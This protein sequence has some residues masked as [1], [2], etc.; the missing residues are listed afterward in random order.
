M[1]VGYADRCNNS[2]KDEFGQVSWKGKGELIYSFI[3]SILTGA[4]PAVSADEVFEA[5]S[6]CLAIEK[7]SRQE[8]NLLSLN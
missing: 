5:M 8:S 1:S 7:A 2:G 6:V 4:E 3:D